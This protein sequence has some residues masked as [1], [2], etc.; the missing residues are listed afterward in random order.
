MNLLT[1]DTLPPFLQQVIFTRELEVGQ[2]LFRQGDAA[3]AVFVVEAGR[4]RLVRSTIEG[5]VVPIQFASPGQSVGDAALFSASYSYT[6]IAEVA[7]SVLVYPKQ[8][9]MFA[10]RQNPDLAEDVI[11]ILLRKIQSFEVSLELKAIKSAQQRI[12]RYLQY[13]AMPEQANVV[14]IDRPWKE[15]ADELG[16]TPDT[17]SRALT[18]LEREGSISRRQQHITLHNISAA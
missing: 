9:L 5:K 17:L 15:I 10:L 6:A 8:E 4:L 18:K 1:F 11:A 14:Q 7:S 13:L 3:Y 16:F 2:R 12:L